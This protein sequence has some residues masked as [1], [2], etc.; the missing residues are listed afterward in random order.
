MKLPTRLA[1]LTPIV[2]NNGLSAAALPAAQL[3]EY[4]S[5]PFDTAVSLAAS[6]DANLSKRHERRV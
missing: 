4:F 2:S 1:A 5:Q 3:D 6:L